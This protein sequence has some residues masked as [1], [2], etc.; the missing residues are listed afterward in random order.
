MITLKKILV[1]TDYSDHSEKAIRYGIELASKFNSELHLFHAVEFTPVM[2]GEGGGFLSP[3]A[4]MEIEADAARHLESLEVDGAN[5]LRVVRKVVQGHPF[6]AI[7]QYAKENDIDLLVLG[8]H[9]RGAIAH[10]LLGSVAEQ[11]V[12]KAPCPVLV[13]RDEAH[14]FIMP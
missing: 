6:V 7:V 1:P 5:G 12:R 2:Y 11:V 3:D 10:M 13:V 14:D 4:A 9:G 8:T